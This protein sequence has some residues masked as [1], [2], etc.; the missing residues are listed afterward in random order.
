[1]FKSNEWMET[2][3]KGAQ[4][5]KGEGYLKP[6]SHLQQGWDLMF[7]WYDMFLIL[8]HR[9]C[10]FGFY[11]NQSLPNSF[12]NLKKKK[13]LF[14]SMLFSLGIKVEKV[15]VCTDWKNISREMKG[16]HKALTLPHN[17]CVSTWQ[18]R[19]QITELFGGLRFPLICTFW[20]APYPLCKFRAPFERMITEVWLIV[21]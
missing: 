21:K 4:H 6:T 10:A 16:L 9:D 14:I 13:V 7:Q 19:I 3:L 17:K 15:R 2:V 5:Y 11:I 12:R 8:P 20:L 1:M 18:K